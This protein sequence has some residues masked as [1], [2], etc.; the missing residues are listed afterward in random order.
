MT[1]NIDHIWIFR[2]PRIPINCLRQ[3]DTEE[4]KIF[5]YSSFL[6]ICL[7]MKR[8]DHIEPQIQLLYKFIAELS[9]I[10]R[11]IISLE[12]GKM[13]GKRDIAQIIGFV[14]E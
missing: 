13:S 11:R 4:S 8:T 3:L 9:E 2:I 10:D 5:I 7:K 14:G 1:A 12:L 6:P